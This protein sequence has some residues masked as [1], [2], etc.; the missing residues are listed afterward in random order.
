V[1][2]NP[3]KLGLGMFQSANVTGIE[4]ETR[5]CVAVRSALSPN[6]G[7]GFPVGGSVAQRTRGMTSAAI[8]SR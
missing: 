6:V 2:T 1:V 8:S 4:P 3:A 5:I 7:T